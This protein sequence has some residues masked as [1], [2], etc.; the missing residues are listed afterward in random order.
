MPGLVCLFRKEGKR[1]LWQV[2]VD[3]PEIAGTAGGRGGGDGGRRDLVADF[4][5]G[6]A[7]DKVAAVVK[8]GVIAGGRGARQDGDA[9]C[10]DADRPDGSQDRVA[11][12]VVANGRDEPCAETEAGKNS[13]DIE[14]D[15]AGNA[16][17]GSGIRRAHDRR[18]GALGD[19]VQRRATEDGD[20]VKRPDDLVHD[21]NPDCGRNA[22]MPFGL[23]A[24]VA[25]T[26]EQNFEYCRHIFRKLN[27]LNRLIS[28]MLHSL[29]NSSASSLLQ[30]NR[31]RAPK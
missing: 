28:A 14:A 13:C 20:R 16:P 17:D 12:G 15:A 24:I 4:H 29:T 30:S 10:V 6:D 3:H 26:R 25:S 5:I 31:S 23:I 21:R 2:G 8:R 27:V 22:Q 9:G 1:L 18:S 19:A 11:V 7:D